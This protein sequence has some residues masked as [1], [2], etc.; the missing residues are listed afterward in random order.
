MDFEDVDWNNYWG[1]KSS[2]HEDSAVL[3]MPSWGGGSGFV[4]GCIL[5]TCVPHL[6]LLDCYFFCL[7]LI[8][9]VF[10]R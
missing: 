2:V 6:Y 4:L 1:F 3:D 5:M 7:V 9:T 10:F 8:L